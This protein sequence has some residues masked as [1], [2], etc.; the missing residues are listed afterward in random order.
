M[1][2]MTIGERI[3]AIRKHR[4]MTVQELAKAAGLSN[5]AISK[6]EREPRNPRADTLQRTADALGVSSSFLMGEED[7]D[8]LLKQA[9]AQ[10]SLKRLLK[11]KKLSDVDE[12]YLRRV[13]KLE[14]APDTE[15]AW[16]ALLVNARLYPQ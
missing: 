7:D 4:R 10:Q 9:L 15:E 14:T 6:I 3:K 1:T 13:A 12:E 16:E 8:L 2:P 5:A 11:K